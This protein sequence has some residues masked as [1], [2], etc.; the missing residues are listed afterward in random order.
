MNF[1]SH[2]LLYIYIYFILLFL[3]LFYYIYIY[4]YIYNHLQ[5][6]ALYLNVIN[7][8]A[9]SFVEQYYKIFDTNRGVS[10][11]IY[12][13]DILIK[14]KYLNV[15]YIYK[16]NKCIINFKIIYIPSYLEK[17]KKK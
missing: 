3:L 16:I 6:S 14:K 5:Q 1:S 4:I 8:G 17:K 13:I 10:L 7:K 11:N 2:H 9:T 12:I 15:I